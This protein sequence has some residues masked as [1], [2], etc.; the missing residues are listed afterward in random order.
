MSI[1]PKDHQNTSF[2]RALG[3]FIYL[4]MPFGLCNAPNVFQSVMTF[5]FFDLLHNSMSVFMDDIKT[6]TLY[7]IYFNA[8]G[9][10]VLD[11]LFGIPKSLCRWVLYD[12]L[13]CS[14]ISCIVDVWNLHMTTDVWEVF[15]GKSLL[16]HI[17]S[18]SNWKD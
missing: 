4:V 12:F 11:T 5:I 16:V 18:S 7:P 9:M 14:G 13:Y 1:D 15:E 3:T 17:Q 10:V 8:W 2:I 6:Q